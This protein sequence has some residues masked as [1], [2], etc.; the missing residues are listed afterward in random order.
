[1]DAMETTFPMWMEKYLAPIHNEFIF[2]AVM[3]LRYFNQ[4]PNTPPGTMLRL[5]LD[6]TTLPVMC[7]LDEFVRDQNFDRLPDLEVQ[8]EERLPQ[9]QKEYQ[10]GMS[11]KQFILYSVPETSELRSTL[12]LFFDRDHLATRVVLYFDAEGNIYRNADDQDGEAG[13]PMLRTANMEDGVDSGHRVKFT[14]DG[15]MDFLSLQHDEEDDYSSW[16]LPDTLVTETEGPKEYRWNP[17]LN[18]FEGDLPFLEHLDPIAWWEYYVSKKCQALQDFKFTAKLFWQKHRLD[19]SEDK[20][21]EFYER[22]AKA[23]NMFMEGAAILMNMLYRHDCENR[24]ETP[25]ETGIPYP[26][27]LRLR[28]RHERRRRTVAL[29]D[30]QPLLPAE[31][32][33]KKTDLRQWWQFQEKLSAQKSMKRQSC[34][35]KQLRGR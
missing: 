31:Q 28:G 6:I 35:K 29:P 17:D 4:V 34:R 27:A 33:R 9:L 5:T 12:T 7:K 2:E 1:M 3:Q 13:R 18:N 22:I 30:V 10:Y 14:Q 26:E 25:R 11:Q 21:R 15:W 32:R 16:D 20:A 19:M 8:S 23:D 24:G